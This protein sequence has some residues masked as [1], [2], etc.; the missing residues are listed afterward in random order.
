MKVYLSS[1][2]ATEYSSTTAWTWVVGSELC[3]A[4][5]HIFNEDAG[6]NTFWFNEPKTILGG[7]NYA[8]I[9]VDSNENWALRHTFAS[10]TPSGN[11]TLYQYSNATPYD[12]IDLPNSTTEGYLIAKRNNVRFIT[13]PMTCSISGPASGQTGQ[14]LTFTA[15]SPEGASYSWNFAGG[16]PA[17]ATGTSASTTWN[18]A[19]TYTVTLTATRGNQTATATKNVT[20]TNGVGIEEINAGDVA[21]Y[22]NPT[23]GILNIEAEGLLCTELMDITGRNILT[24]TDNTID[25]SNLST[26][27]YMIRVQTEQGTT[28]RRVV[29]K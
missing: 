2:A 4:G 24:T 21:I 7:Y 13:T 28:V 14:T 29:R 22:P 5:G 25:L 1:T 10:H 15:S 12:A 3:Y 18:T 17:T 16:T 23:T 9:T 26:G 19:G 8:L 11:T 6:W 27:V 20:I